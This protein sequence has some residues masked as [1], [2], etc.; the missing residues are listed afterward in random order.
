MQLRVYP[1]RQRGEEAP[2]K[3]MSSSPFFGNVCSS[4]EPPNVSKAKNLQDEECMHEM[5]SYGR[6]H[7]YVLHNPGICAILELCQRRL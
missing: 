2:T 6:R 7:I 3:T 1:G 5:H 4:A